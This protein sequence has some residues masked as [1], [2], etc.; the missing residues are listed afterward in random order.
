[1]DV[2]G[3]AVPLDRV[4]RFMPMLAQGL[5]QAKVVVPAAKAI[6]RTICARTTRID[7]RVLFF[8]LSQSPSSAASKIR[9][10][11]TRSNPK[12]KANPIQKIADPL[13]DS[14]LL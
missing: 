3:S 4:S 5:A 1:M 12:G 6:A 2:L 14:V 10:I 13:Y 8:T 11:A 9:K 7:F